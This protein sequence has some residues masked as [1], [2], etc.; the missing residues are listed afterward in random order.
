MMVRAYVLAMQVDNNLKSS[1]VNRV[2]ETTY[3]FLKLRTSHLHCMILRT[4][5]FSGKILQLEFGFRDYDAEC[6]GLQGISA[7]KISQLRN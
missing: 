5:V 2:I 7:F 6:S 1:E 3:L 4:I